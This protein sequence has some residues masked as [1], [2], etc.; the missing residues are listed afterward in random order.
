MERH[1]RIWREKAVLREYYE[2]EYFSRVVAEL[3]P[4][5]TLEVGAGPGFFAQYKRSDVVSDITPAP[6]VDQVVDVHAMPFADNEFDA[7]VGVDVVH[8]F[9]SPSLAFSEVS[10][11]LKPGGRLVLIEPWT[12]PLGFLFHRYFHHEDCFSIPDPWGAVFPQGKDPMAGNAA[13]PKTYFH[14]HAKALE[15]RTGLRTVK[16]ETFS[17]FGFV[18]TGGF[19]A[20]SFP[21]PLPRMILASERLPPQF[22]WRQAGLKA[23]IVAEKVD[24]PEQ[25]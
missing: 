18:A 15:E 22:F 1:Q 10:R 4:G 9:A 3:P 19:T 6:H 16:L 24:R 12:G 7:V 23:L 20:W 14:D 21:K 2:R 17:F 11:V 13:I 8:H 5:R 25:A